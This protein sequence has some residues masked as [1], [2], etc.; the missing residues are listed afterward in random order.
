MSNTENDPLCAWCGTRV[1]RETLLCPYDAA[2]HR[3]QSDM[4]TELP[5][6]PERD[7]AYE[8]AAARARGNDFAE[9]DGRDWT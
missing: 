6:E 8:R 7:E 4:T 2:H 1:D 9:T 5:D 3:E